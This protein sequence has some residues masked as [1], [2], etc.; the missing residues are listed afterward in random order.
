MFPIGGNIRH[1]FQYRKMAV[2]LG[3]QDG[4]VLVPLDGEPLI[5]ENGKVTLGKK[6]ELKNV[7]V[8]GLGI[9]DVGNVVLRDRR[10][11]ASDGIVVVIVPI[12]EQTGKVSGEIQIVSR[13]FVYMKQSGELIKKLKNKVSESL[14]RQEQVTDWGHVRNK[15]Q[16]S[17]EG[18]IFRETERRPL[19]MPVIVEV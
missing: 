19:I 8:D 6:I 12:A 16:D 14:K 4:N 9:G 17:L 10:A 3:Y 1:Q 13:G 2:N 5:L 18:F 7:Y 15:I 11:M